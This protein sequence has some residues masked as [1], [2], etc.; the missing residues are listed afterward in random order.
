MSEHEER[1][2]EPAGEYDLPHEAGTTLLSGFAQCGPCRIDYDHNLK[3]CDKVTGGIRLCQKRTTNDTVPIETVARG[4][5]DG[6]E[7][8]VQQCVQLEAEEAKEFARALLEY[9]ED[10]ERDSSSD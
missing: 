2:H 3:K 6:T 1:E 10:M 7:F 9:A 8:D 4:L 5:F